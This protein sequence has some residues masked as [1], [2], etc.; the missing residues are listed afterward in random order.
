M[1][2]GKVSAD[3]YLDDDLFFCLVLRLLEVLSARLHIHFSHVYYMVWTKTFVKRSVCT[4]C[5][6]FDT[7]YGTEYKSSC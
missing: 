2:P 7:K 5:P 3:A 4:F 6:G 1:V